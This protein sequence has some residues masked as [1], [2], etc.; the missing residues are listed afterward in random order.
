MCCGVV[1]ERKEIEVKIRL[2]R[3][4]TELPVGWLVPGEEWVEKSVV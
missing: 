1:V 4:R 3:K 2:V